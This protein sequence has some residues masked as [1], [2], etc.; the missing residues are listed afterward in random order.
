MTLSMQAREVTK[1]PVHGRGGATWAALPSHVGAFTIC[2]NNGSN[3]PGVERR[4]NLLYKRLLYPK[5]LVI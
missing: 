3:F 5:T 2:D 4:S 1:A